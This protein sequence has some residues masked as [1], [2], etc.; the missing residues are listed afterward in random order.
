[1]PESSSWGFGF[2]FKGFF[3]V[4]SNDGTTKVLPMFVGAWLKAK[5]ATHHIQKLHQIILD[6]PNFGVRRTVMD[7][8]GGD[9]FRH[10]IYETTPMPN[11]P[12]LVGDIVGNLRSSLDHQVS[13]AYR[14][15]IG[16]DNDAYWPF[17]DNRT[18]LKSRI[19]GTLVK[20]GFKELAPLFLDDIDCTKAGNYPLWALNKL[21]NANKHRAI[22]VTTHLAVV[23]EVSYTAEFPNGGG[24]ISEANKIG[25]IPGQKY[26]ARIPASAVIEDD[27]NTKGT[28][29][30]SFGPSEEFAGLE[31]I[32]TLHDLCKIVLQCLEKFQIA[33]VSAYR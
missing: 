11:L 10:V 5:W 2:M 16:R 26:T 14:E 12:L 7:V 4:S 27:R 28:L 32:P 21:S 19:D 6:Y 3:T 30:A 31:V 33:Y 29:H 22:V 25:L 18:N 9:D 24:I 23:P 15:R 13:A 17:G 20:A 8:Q 1:M